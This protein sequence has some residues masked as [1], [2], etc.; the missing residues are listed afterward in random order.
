M[1]AKLFF[2]L[3]SQAMRGADTRLSIIIKRQII[4]K[5]E[6][7]FQYKKNVWMFQL[8]TGPSTW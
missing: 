8:R 3:L 7:N 5:S 6:K 4:K 2:T 1:E